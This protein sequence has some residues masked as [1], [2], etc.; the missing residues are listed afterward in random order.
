V[1]VVGS[2]ISLVQHVGIVLIHERGPA[3]RA[4][5]V[6]P[7]RVTRVTTVGTMH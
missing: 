3:E 1:V 2:R 5:I 6:I 7:S 4:V